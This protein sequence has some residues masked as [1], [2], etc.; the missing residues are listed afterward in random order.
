M[1][2]TV[3]RIDKI[4]KSV[5]FSLSWHSADKNAIYALCRKKFVSRKHLNLLNISMPNMCIGGD[6]NSNDCDPLTLGSQ[7]FSSYFSS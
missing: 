1:M 4:D 6:L 7:F 2:C 5:H 3:L